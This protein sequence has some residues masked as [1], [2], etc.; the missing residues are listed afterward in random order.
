[1]EKTNKISDLELKSLMEEV[2]LSIIL[3]I[4]ESTTQPSGQSV[5]LQSF[6]MEIPV[7][8]TKFKGLWDQKNIKIWKI[9]LS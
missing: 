6:A 1:M 9:Y 8:I 4:Y 2:G 5:A 3:P 7:L